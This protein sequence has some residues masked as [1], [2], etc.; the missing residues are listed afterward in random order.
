[1]LPVQYTLHRQALHDDLSRTSFVIGQQAECS[2]VQAHGRSTQHRSI[3]ALIAYGHSSYRILAKW[4]QRLEHHGCRHPQCCGRSHLRK[5]PA[6]QNGDVR[7]RG[8]GAQ[9]HLGCR[10]A[11]RKSTR[12]Q[13]TFV[14]AVAKVGR[15]LLRRVVRSCSRFARLQK[16][17]EPVKYNQHMIGQILWGSL[18]HLQWSFSGANASCRQ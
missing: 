17:A 2:N 3:P 15:R 5:R 13:S 14:Q 6:R 7:G 16:Y 8:R 18:H 12:E 10:V 9:A 4:T 11:D 1:M